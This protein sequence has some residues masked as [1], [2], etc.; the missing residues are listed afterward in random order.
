MQPHSTSRPGVR[1][2]VALGLLALGG[3][4]P[5]APQGWSTPLRI[6]GP[7][8]A[9]FSEVAVDAEGGVHA[10][11]SAGD[12]FG[13]LVVACRPDRDACSS[14]EQVAKRAGTDGHYTPRP[15]AAV[16][17]AGHLHLIWR[18]KGEVVYQKLFLPD[19]DEGW[20]KPPN[21][22]GSGAYSAI[23]V[24]ADDT[25]HV[26]INTPIFTDQSCFACG[27]IV[28]RRS[29]DGGI[30]WSKGVN[31]SQTADGSD[32]PAFALGPQGELALAWEEGH[33]FYVGKGVGRG[34][35]ITVS[36]DGGLTWQPATTFEDTADPPNSPAVGFDRN[37]A[38]VLVWRH[39]GAAD[40]VFF[41]R[42]NDAGRTW[43]EPAQIDGL[44]SRYGAPDELD[45]LAMARDGAGNLHLLATGR[46]DPKAV[47]NAL[48]HAEWNGETWSAPVDMFR[49]RGAPEWPRLAIGEGNQLHAVWFE[50]PEGEV[51]KSEQNGY[52]IWYAHAESAAPRRSAV[53]WERPVKPLIN[54]RKASVVAQTLAAFLIVGGVI[55]WARR[56]GL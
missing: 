2:A 41:R 47:I 43:S 1:L 39:R 30:S 12:S 21:R 13:D 54:P 29:K 34:I 46:M 52:G 35:T 32:K 24:G 38:L 7:T 14:S 26:A 27:D 15:A 6:S 4:A 36:L 9:W 16:D 44:R 19:P 5:A 49:T 28:Y 23:A 50:R 17:S 51:W 25:I 48:Y 18:A 10:F 53:R 11:W 56:H 22:L 33:D 42:S 20:S 31:L 8:K 55:F 45:D 37:G 40:G 3:N